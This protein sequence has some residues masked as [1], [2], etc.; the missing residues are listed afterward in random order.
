MR[1]LMVLVLILALAP[2]VCAATVEFQL[3]GGGTTVVAG[4]TVTINNPRLSRPSPPGLPP[5]SL[6][7]LKDGSVNDIVI[8]Q[9]YGGVGI[10]S[11][12]IPPGEPS[13]YFDI[14]AGAA[15]TTLT[16]DD[17]TGTNPFP[18][19]PC[20]VQTNIGIN[21]GMITDIVGLSLDI[22][23]DPCAGTVEFQ[24]DG[25]G[26]TVVAGST[27]TINVVADVGVWVFD[28][29][30]ITV[31]G[32]T[33]P[34]VG[35]L[36]PQLRHKSPSGLPPLSRGTLKDGSVNDIVIYQIYGSTG[37]SSIPAPA[38]DPSYLFDV[39]AGAA[40]TTLTIDDWTG[41]NPFGQEPSTLQTNINAGTITDIVGLS[42]D[43]VPDP[44][45]V[46]VEFQLDGGGTTVVAGSTVTI[47][48][49]ADV[50]V[51]GHFAV[52]AITVSSGAVPAVG[53]LN[54]QLRHKS[55]PGF[56]P[57]S[58][59]TLKDGSVNDIVIFQ[60]YGST[61]LSSWPVPA[62]EPSYLF[63]VVA[64]EA[65]TTLTIDDWT[66][67]NPFPGEPFTVQTNIGTWHSDTNDIV[68][69]SLDIVPD[70]CTVIEATVEI[71][72]HTL[73]LKSK[74]KWIT[75]YIWLPEDYNVADVNSYSVLLEDEIGVEWIWF[76]EQEQVLMAK[77]SRSALQEILADLETPIQVE[78]LVTGELIDG[79]IF[80]GTDTIK[81][82]NKGRKK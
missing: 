59:G 1:K 56:P 3:D 61:G 22:V 4:S 9:I 35:T 13:Y 65:G 17:W 44:C 71:T 11:I 51:W 21:I 57:L 74:G 33:V 58:H 38:G 63:D 32:G 68:G 67:T 69:L 28:V 48:V 43:I 81:V 18:G 26:T 46:I 45:A 80:E 19:E 16:I 6:G 5:I 53:T 50:D 78:L 8:Y 25:G 70:P 76:E 12:P 66:G 29:G 23:P 34:A 41:T 7:T 20:D 72:P 42:L 54:P 10:S 36:N 40:G 77:F 60:I 82:I 2:V 39:V 37:L 14:V 15:G 24:L 30:A 75:C 52:G 27:A 62:G 73:N 64:G 79:T 31:N 55:P 49:V 47:N